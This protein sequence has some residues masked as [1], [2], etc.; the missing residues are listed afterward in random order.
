[1]PFKA[2]YGMASIE[3]GVKSV[4]D[5]GRRS[6][7]QKSEQESLE[8]KKQ[9]FSTFMRLETLFLIALEESGPTRGND[10]NRVLMDPSHL[11]Y[12]Q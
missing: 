2:N 11:K 6:V 3:D 10:F 12:C 9:T 1:M 4:Y 8:K 7:Q 5:E